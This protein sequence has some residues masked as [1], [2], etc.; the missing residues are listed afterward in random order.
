MDSQDVRFSTR[1]QEKELQNIESTE[2]PGKSYI[3]TKYNC[4]NGILQ[5]QCYLIETTS[6]KMKLF[7]YPKNYFKGTS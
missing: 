2:E 3:I 4:M 7:C 5:R 6:S 1:L